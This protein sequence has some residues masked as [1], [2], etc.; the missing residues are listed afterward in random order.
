LI[1]PSDPLVA[2]QRVTALLNQMDVRVHGHDMTSGLCLW[3]GRAK[4]YAVV[5]HVGYALHRTLN[6]WCMK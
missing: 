5:W 3:H 6:D 1:G 4:R 2:T